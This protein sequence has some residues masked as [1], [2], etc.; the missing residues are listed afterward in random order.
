M[1]IRKGNMDS[2]IIY[3]YTAYTY[4]LCILCIYAY[5]NSSSMS[6]QYLYIANKTKSIHLIAMQNKYLD[7]QSKNIIKFVIM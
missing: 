5:S 1:E 7:C 6:S 2:S 3:T 4:A